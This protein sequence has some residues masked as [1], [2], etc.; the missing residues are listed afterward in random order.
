M[1][2]DDYSFCTL[3]EVKNFM[4]GSRDVSDDVEDGNMELM[5]D[6]V[7]VGME[8]YMDRKIL[9]REDTEYYDG[10]GTKHLFL[11]RYPITTVSGVWDDTDWSWGSSTLIASTSYR[12]RNDGRGLVM[13]NLVFNKFNQNVKVIY[14]AGYSSTPA[15]LKMACIEETARRFHKKRD[16]NIYSKT[17]EDGTN[18][19]LQHD[20]LPHN[21]IIMD[22]YK[23]K[24]VL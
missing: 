15:D 3:A 2:V 11:D 24:D 16:I 22:K 21:Q 20:F 7:S 5:I 4:L 23:R 6:A 13:N 1:P 19:F 10:D 9:S 18:V 17:M 12:T 14:T 8:T